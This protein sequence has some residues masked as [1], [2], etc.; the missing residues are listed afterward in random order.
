M[1]LPG[2][3]ISCSNSNATERRSRREMISG[4]RLF[5]SVFLKMPPKYQ[6]RHTAAVNRHSLQGMNQNLVA[7]AVAMVIPAVAVIYVVILERKYVPEEPITAE[8]VLMIPA[9]SKLP[10]PV[11]KR[12]RRLWSRLK[13]RTT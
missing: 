6:G 9:L 7:V 3:S 13:N 12:R 5:N 2:N 4:S 10:P 11:V 8:I 1:E